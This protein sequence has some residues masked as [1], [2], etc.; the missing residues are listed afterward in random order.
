MPHWYVRFPRHSKKH[1]SRAEAQRKTKKYFSHE[2]TK[3]GFYWIVQF[4]LFSAL[5]WIYRVVS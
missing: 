5:F 2:A 1:Y 3:K 4:A